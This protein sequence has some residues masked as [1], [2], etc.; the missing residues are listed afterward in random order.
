MQ[1]SYYLSEATHPLSF[2]NNYLPEK[3]MLGQGTTKPWEPN[4]V[5]DLLLHSVIQYGGKVVVYPLTKTTDQLLEVW[6]FHRSLYNHEAQ[7]RYLTWKCT[8]IKYLDRSSYNGVNRNVTDFEV[9]EAEKHPGKYIEMVSDM[10]ICY[11]M[12]LLS[13]WWCNWKKVESS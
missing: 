10:L 4:P 5:H 7:V 2:G 1:Q 8:A 11:G 13:A 12:Q 6:P 3:Y 9:R